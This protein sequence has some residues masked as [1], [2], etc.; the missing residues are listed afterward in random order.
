MAKFSRSRMVAIAAVVP[1][2]V[3]AG[4]D[5]SPTGPPSPGAPCPALHATAPDN[6]GH[7]MWCIHMIDGPDHPVWQYNGSW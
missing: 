5:P 2:A 7:T 4:T 3:A 6:H 1:L